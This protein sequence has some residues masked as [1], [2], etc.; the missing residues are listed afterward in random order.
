M[1]DIDKFCNYNLKKY[2]IEIL[3]W[4]FKKKLSLKIRMNC[5]LHL[6]RKIRVVTINYKNKTDTSVMIFSLN[7]KFYWTNYK[8]NILLLAIGRLMDHQNL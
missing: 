8:E 7:N 1:K 6:N 2:S 5:F 3:D 4:Q